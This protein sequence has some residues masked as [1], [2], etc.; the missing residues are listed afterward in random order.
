MITSKVTHKT[1]DPAECV[2]LSNPVQCHKYF[3][4]L[5]SDLFVDIL[6]ASEKRPDALVYVWRKCA[7]T[8]KA[9]ELWDKR[10]L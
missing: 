3:E 5:G 1:Y 6:W 10:L 2:F 8:A 7:E 9:K 4:L